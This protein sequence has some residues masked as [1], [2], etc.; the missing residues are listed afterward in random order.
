MS[1]ILAGFFHSIFLCLLIYSPLLGIGLMDEEEI[2]VEA[3]ENTDLQPEASKDQRLE[4]RKAEKEEAEKIE[5]EKI[6]AEKEEAE[7][8]EAEKEEAEKEEAEKEEA[9]K[10]EAEK[11]EAEKKR[12]AIDGEQ[13]DWIVSWPGKGGDWTLEGFRDTFQIG[14]RHGSHEWGAGSVRKETHVSSRYDYFIGTVSEIDTKSSH[15]FFF[16]TRLLGLAHGP[17]DGN[18]SLGLQLS[19]DQWELTWYKTPQGIRIKE[20]DAHFDDLA[21]GIYVEGSVPPARE[22]PFRLLGRAYLSF[23][24]I[25]CNTTM[26]PSYATDGNQWRDITIDNTGAVT[27]GYELGVV[28]V[29]HVELILGQRF[30]D[31][32]T[33]T[34]RFRKT[35][36]DTGQLVFGFDNDKLNIDSNF[37]YFALSVRGF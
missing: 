10:I 5:A 15:G 35:V 12:Q 20:G 22:I 30:T 28:V 24:S 19:Y 26:D 13:E 3:A 6:E 36:K 21:W 32:K 23:N 2:S 9:E 34:S 16:R 8:E 14:F 37:T 29:R 27:L 7:K 25:S 17:S 11:I 1:H 33:T 31:A 4:K 18:I